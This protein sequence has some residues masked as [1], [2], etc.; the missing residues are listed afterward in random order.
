LSI[1]RALLKNPPIL[2]LDEATASVDTETERLIQEALERLMVN[3]TS[4]VIAHRLSTVR[5][6]DRIYVMNLGEVVEQGTHAELLAQ[7][8]LYAELCRTA[9]LDESE[10]KVEG[11]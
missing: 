6:A 11:V 3:R 7:G 1:A 2:L 5:H 9:F 10:G 4:F 8:G